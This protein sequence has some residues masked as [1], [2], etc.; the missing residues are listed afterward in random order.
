MKTILASASPRRKEL[1]SLAG[2]EYAVV[3]SECEE[4]LPEKILPHEAVILLAKQKAEDVFSRNSDCM[5][6]A[7][8]TVVALEDKILGKPKDAEDA[9]NMLSELSGRQHTVYTGVCIMTKAKTDC[10][11]VGTDV[12]F[13]SLTEKEIR[14]YIATKEPMDKAGAYGIQGKGFVLVKGIHGDYFNVVGLPLAE[15]VRHIA[16]FDC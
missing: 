6:I 11:F 15:T 7:A 9:F 10:F 12:E 1:L 4:I 5:V 2:I 3:V 8:D 14:E 16:S 13:Y